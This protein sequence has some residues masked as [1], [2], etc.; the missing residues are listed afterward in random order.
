[1]FDLSAMFGISTYGHNMHSASNTTGVSR[2]PET[3]TPANNVG[4]AMPPYVAGGN[5]C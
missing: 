3:N 4:M 1:M 5:P 2:Q